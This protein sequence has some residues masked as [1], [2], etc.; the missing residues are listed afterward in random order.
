MPITVCGFGSLAVSHHS[1]LLTM[2][3]VAILDAG[4]TALLAITLLPAHPGVR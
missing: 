4:A 2:G 1:W 3:Y